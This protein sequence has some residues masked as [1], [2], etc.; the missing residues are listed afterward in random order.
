[1][2]NSKY[3][4]TK[5]YAS[6]QWLKEEITRKLRNILRLMKIFQNLWDKLNPCLEGSL[7]S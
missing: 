1:M 4:E 6:K 3:V 7:Y 5:Q 2:T